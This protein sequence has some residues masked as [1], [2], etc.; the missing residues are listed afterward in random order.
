[1]LPNSYLSF[2]REAFAGTPTIFKEIIS[3]DIAQSMLTS[4]DIM[5]VTLANVA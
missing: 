4:S 3:P 1:M 2:V 5:Y